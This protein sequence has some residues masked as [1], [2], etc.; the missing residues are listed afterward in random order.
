MA[1]V[2]LTNEGWGFTSL[3]FVC[4][5]A[6]DLGMRVPFF[7]DDERGVVR[8]EFTLTERFSGAPEL[9]HGGAL[10][11]LC[12]E[13]MSWATIAVAKSFAVTQT[14]TTTFTESSW[15]SPRRPMTASR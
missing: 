2:R 12:D 8:A 13:A 5:D 7:H 6:N 9:A 3:C 1:L 10:M 11:A 14:T 15:S 4:E